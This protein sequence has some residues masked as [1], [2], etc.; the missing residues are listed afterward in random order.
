MIVSLAKI[1]FPSLQGHRL[2]PF[3]KQHRRNQI[4]E[5]WT[6]GALDTLSRDYGHS[7]SFSI[8][9]WHSER[10]KCRLELAMEIPVAI[11]HTES[12]PLTGLHAFS[13]RFGCALPNFVVPVLCV[14]VRTFCPFF[15]SCSA[16][17]EQVVIRQEEIITFNESASIAIH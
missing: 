9:H 15:T 7:H 11:A 10:R 1:N 6:S 17:Y 12:F 8:V 14:F 4:S 13:T 3:M 2:P 5:R 16:M